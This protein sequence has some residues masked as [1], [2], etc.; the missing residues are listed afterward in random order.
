ME[1]NRILENNENSEAVENTEDTA[2]NNGAPDS[3]ALNTELEALAELFRTE[4]AKTAEEYEAAAEEAVSEEESETEAS[5]EADEDELI[6][7]RCGATYKKGKDGICEICLDE[8]RLQPLKFKNI[9][10]LILGKP[11]LQLQDI[12]LDFVG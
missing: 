2:V 3:E 1:D 11:L 12:W 4:L 6:C 8:L 7:E 10:E 9:L 5:E